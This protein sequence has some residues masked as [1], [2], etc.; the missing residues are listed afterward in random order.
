MAEN[1]NY[2]KYV[3]RMPRDRTLPM[4]GIDPQLLS[5]AEKFCDQN[6]ENECEERGGLYQWH[7]MMGF[8]TGCT[9]GTLDCGDRISDGNHQGICPKGWHIPSK[10]EWTAVALFSGGTLFFGDI[11]NVEALV[12]EEIGGDNSSGLNIYATNQTS[13]RGGFA[14]NSNEA[15]YHGK[16]GEGRSDSQ[17]IQINYQ[18]AAASVMMMFSEKS[19]HEAL[20]NKSLAR[21]VRCVK[22]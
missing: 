18:Y 2:G 12:T 22:D 15:F 16:R 13:M 3:E 5:G 1:L 4:D 6:D 19:G 11:T 7:T 10:E 14:T 20:V 21:P 8:E 9:D 17:T